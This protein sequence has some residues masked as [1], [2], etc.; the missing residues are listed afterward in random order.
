MLGQCS[1]ICGANH[2][3]MPVVVESVPS[4]PMT[5]PNPTLNLRS[6]IRRRGLSSSV[7]SLCRCLKVRVY[8]FVGWTLG[9]QPLGYAPW[10]FGLWPGAWGTCLGP[11]GLGLLPWAILAWAFAFWPEELECPPEDLSTLRQMTPFGVRKSGEAI[12]CWVGVSVP[13]DTRRL[14][15]GGP[16][17]GGSVK[18]SVPK[19]TRVARASRTLRTPDANGGRDN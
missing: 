19:D 3:F 12:G 6:W 2:R 5:S 8:D 16:P 9:L 17:I 10:A 4:K 1:E 18:V 11:L 15:R 14:G 13:E 7:G